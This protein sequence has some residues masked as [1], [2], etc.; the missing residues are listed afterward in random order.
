MKNRWKIYYSNSV[1]FSSEDG[2]PRQAPFWDVQDIIQFNPIKEKKYH[3]NQ[4]D[5]YIFQNGYWSGVDF[6]GLIDY[7]AHYDGE[8]IIKVG[9]TIATDKWLKI[10][11]RAKEDDFI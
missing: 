7:L 8:Y 5:Y 3:Q 10:F 2:T 11:N 4:S 1:T 9:R 6:M